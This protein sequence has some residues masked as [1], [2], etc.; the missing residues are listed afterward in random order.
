MGGKYAVLISGDLA[1]TGYDEFWNDV[2]LM[3]EALLQN[4]FLDDHIFVLYGNG[5]DY[6]SASRPNPRYRPSPSITDHSADTANV[7][8]V[9]NGLA[10]G[11]G[12]F[13]QMTDEDLLFIWT[14]DHGCGRPCIPGTVHST[15][16]LM[17]GDMQDTTFA[18]LVNPIPHAHRAIC[19][20]QC[21]SGGF[22]DD[23]R[24]DKTVIITACAEDEH[25]HRA[26]SPAENEVVDG[27]TYH[28]GEFNYYLLATLTGQ[29]VTGTPVNAD[30]D[31]DGYVMM[32]EV[33]DYVQAHESRPETP[34]YDDG[35]K[36]LGEKLHLSE[37]R[38]G[39][40]APVFEA[41]SFP[42]CFFLI[43]VYLVI[44]GSL[45]PFFWYPKVLCLIKQYVYRIRNCTRGNSDPNIKL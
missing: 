10:N 9:F 34:Q 37:V 6:F 27:V 35:T 14:F 41:R 3:R 30:A 44:V 17:D 32:R 4:G 31:G 45:A 2:V 28:H 18:G 39:C 11:T 22:I 29:T 5:T 40:Y 19:M 23:L 24:S 13:P 42:E 1:E 36:N 7:T 33:F 16:G 43:F 26:D 8:A 38:K 12:G 25:A 20:Q 15:L 21:H